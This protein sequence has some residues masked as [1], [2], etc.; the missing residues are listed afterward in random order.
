MIPQTE[1]PSQ[2]AP[3]S[4]N[5]PTA[6]ESWQ[7]AL[8]GVIRNPEELFD[9]LQL[10]KN[11]LSM[12]QRATL[13]F[14]L[15]VPRAFVERMARGDWNDPL[16]LQVLPQREELNFTPGFSDDPLQESSSN[17]CPGLIHKY[18]GRVLL[19][20]SGGCAIN[21]RYCFRRHFPYAD[22]IPNREQ[23]QQSL[24]YIRRDDS[25]HEVIFSGG[26]PLA[27]TDDLLA[28]RVADLAAISHIAT[29]RVHSRLPIV[30]PQRIT[31]QCLQWLTGSRLQTVMVVHSNHANEIDAAVGNS[32]LKLNRAGITVLNQT[33][34]LAGIN[35]DSTTLAAL[36]QRLFQFGVL[37]Y[38]LHLLD[39]VQGAAHFEVS[40]ADGVQLSRELLATLPGYLVPRL[41]RE[42]AN[43]SSKLPI[44][45]F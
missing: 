17:P 36:S 41:V 39:R 32:L 11:Q 30:I 29:L 5:Q 38:Y 27:A 13:T 25:I 33:V 21:C 2:A 20:I 45:L 4:Q 15:R 40:E 10:D 37:P 9:Q 1:R 16:L 18:Q 35:N 12:A 44:Q 26:D 31:D 6:N 14:P 24:D 19:V 43:A 42:Q 22:N 34:L 8:A 3:Y 23:W 7:Q 28:E